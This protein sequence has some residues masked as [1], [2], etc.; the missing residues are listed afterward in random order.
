MADDL[1]EVL[2]LLHDSDRRWRTLR[3]EGDQWADPERSREAFLR[4]VRPGGVASVRGTPGPADM[5]PTWK[6]WMAP[7]RFRAD[8]GVPHQSRMLIIGDGRRVCA[9][10]PAVPH[11]RVT[12][13]RADDQPHIGPAGEL[14]RPAGLPAVLRLE[15]AGR[16]TFLGRD[17]FVVRGRPRPEA[18]HHG[19][20]MFFAADEVE[21]GV[22]AERGVLLWKEQRLRQS[23]FRRVAMTSVA[24]DEDLDPAL[25]EFPDAPQVLESSLP[26]PGEPRRPPAPHGPPGP[27]YTVLGEPLAGH[28]VVARAE[29]L[30]IAVDRLV[31]YPTGFEFGITVRT[32]DV[33]VSGSFDEV[34]RRAWSGSSAFPG[35]S[36][37]VGVVFADGRRSFFENFPSNRMGTGDLRLVPMGGGGT[38]NRIDQRFWVEPLPPPGP[39]GVVVQWDGR[40]L[41]ETRADLDAGAIVAAAS[42][43]ETLWS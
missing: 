43:A 38:Q 33:P 35:E 18:E 7:P 1:A 27:P 22:D 11:L 29:A 17:V 2:R 5:D 8:V 12:D 13:Q 37:Q 16:Q 39:L 31:A 30:V 6:V 41:P 25:F 28:T 21:F 36:L 40:G 9:S 14:L 32:H 34:R 24:F 3:A 15:V 42:R 10:H 23:A 4:N 19:P 26:V 20:R